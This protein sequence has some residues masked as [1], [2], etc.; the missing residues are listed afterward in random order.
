LGGAFLHTEKVLLVDRSGRLRGVY[1]GTLPFD[2][3]RLL[4]DITQLRAAR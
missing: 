3:D 1:N 4:G 2:I